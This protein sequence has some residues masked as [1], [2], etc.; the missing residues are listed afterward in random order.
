VGAVLQQDGHPIAYMSKPLSVRHRGLSTYEKECL[1]ILMAV[2]QWRPYLHAGEFL[3]R[4]D[5][6]SLIHLEEQKLTTIWQQKAF[7]KLL[8]LQYRICYRKGEENRAADALSRRLHDD[9]EQLATISTCQPSWLSEVRSSYESNPQ[10]TRWIQH[11]QQQ[12]DAK[13]RFTL[14]DGILYFRKRI[15]LGGAPQVQQLI[16]HAFHASKLGGHSGFPVTYNRIRPLFA[17]PKMKNQIKEFV[18]SCMTC[19]QAKPERVKYPGLLEPLP[20]PDGAWKMVTMDFIEGLPQSGKFNSIMVVVDKFTKYAHFIP[21]CHPFTAAKVAA[22]YMDNVFKLH[23]LPKVMI[24]DRD[25]I[26][27]SKFW[28]EF[29]SMMGS[30]LRMSSAYHPAT[31]GQSERV[32]QAL[33]IYLRCFTH[34]CPHKWS[35]W[36]A[37]AE[38]WYNTSYDSAIKMSPF[39]ALYGHEPRHWGIESDSVCT[40]QP[41]Q[42]WLEERKLMQQVLQ[43]NLNYA[44]QVMKRQTDKQ[45]T[46][47]TFSVGD[48]VFVKLQP[49]VQVSV[50]RRANHKLAFRYYGPYKI[51]KCINPVAYEVELPASS[52]IHPVFHVSQ[53]RKV[54]VPGTPASSH[55]PDPPDHAVSPVRVLARRWRRTANGV[56]EQVQ[57]EWSDPT[58]TDITWEDVEELKQRF[59]ASAA[60]GQ[61]VPQGEGDVS[62]PGEAVTEDADLGLERRR[63]RPKRMAQPNRRY[64]GPDWVQQPTTKNKS[65]PT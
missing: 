55:P 60:W 4:T 53:L 51:L 31:D 36:I 62:V 25:P 30:E 37:L 65:P 3:I 10:A 20:T 58:A 16:M 26:F 28:K 27:T 24:S 50:A 17:W 48:A 39:V 41:L 34:A 49:Y 11:L 19:Q 23:S 2:E 8:G 40:V 57:I 6:K 33:E 18:Q 46:P 44:R 56:R 9:S 13:G 32:N 21:L 42:T 43:H 59:P 47:R 7:T 35:L 22:A 38:Y 64:L 1:A 12:P 5:Q 52:R 45:R 61:A 15:W 63:T 54:L 14:R 29:F